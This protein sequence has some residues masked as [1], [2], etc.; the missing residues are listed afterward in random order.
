MEKK[1]M[2]EKI[3]LKSLLYWFSCVFFSVHIFFYPFFFYFFFHFLIS[4]S[5][6]FFIF[7]FLSF[8]FLI[9]ISFLIS[10]TLYFSASLLVS[11]LL[12]FLPLS[13]TC[14][15]PT[16][17]PSSILSLC[18]FLLKAETSF[19]ILSSH[20][21]LIFLRF[22]S[23]FWKSFTQEVRRNYLFGIFADE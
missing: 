14:F 15:N 23:W 16:L 17:L 19:I 1:D 2:E 5:S 13:Y 4:L 11:F 6:S 12:C 22:L 7:L 21:T 8:L 18:I 20:Q 3:V 9:S 10:H